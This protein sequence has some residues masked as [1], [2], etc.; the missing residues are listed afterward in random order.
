MLPAV[1]CVTASANAVATAAS[2]ALPPSLITWKPTSDAIA[3][4]EITMPR[5]A[6]YAVEPASTVSDE[7]RTAAASRN[8]RRVMK[9][10]RRELYG[11]SARIVVTGSTRAARRAGNQHA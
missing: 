10:S 4:A 6:R 1:G 9:A 11:Q 3:L 5:L 7:T 8:T 2:M